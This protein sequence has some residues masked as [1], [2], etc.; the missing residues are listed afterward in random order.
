[1]CGADDYETHRPH[2]ADGVAPFKPFCECRCGATWDEDRPIAQPAK[3][4]TYGYAKSLA[5]SLFKK[6]Y[7]H[8][9]PYAS[10]SVVWEV[11]DTIIGVLTQIDNMVCTLVHQKAQP[12]PVQE[13]D[14]WLGYGLQAYTEKPFEDATPVWTSPPAAQPAPVQEPRARLMTYIGKGPYPKPGYTVA[15]TYEECP[16]NQYPDAWSEGE[17]L[18]TT[19]PAAPEKGQP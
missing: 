11:S 16:E 7:A 18:Y 8:Q 15:R 1:M 6:H 13:P 3:D 17:K 5:E 12:A 4:N 10:G 9:E 2:W 19:P 14:Y